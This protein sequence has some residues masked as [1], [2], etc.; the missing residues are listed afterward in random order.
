MLCLPADLQQRGPIKRATPGRPVHPDHKE[1][2]NILILR[3]S[4]DG[5]ITDAAVEAGAAAGADPCRAVLTPA[6]TFHVA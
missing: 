6:S 3:D 4:E 2:D 1:K 5:T